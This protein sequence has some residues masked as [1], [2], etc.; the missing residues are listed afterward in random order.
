MILLPFLAAVVTAAP[1]A[2]VSAQNL[3]DAKCIA[4]IAVTMGN[5]TDETEKSGLTGGL[6]YYI[7]RIDARTPGFD[8]TGEVIRLFNDKNFTEN[9]IKVDAQR[10]GAE[11]TAKG[12][13]V[14]AFGEA[15]RQAG[16]TS[17]D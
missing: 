5:A 13:E 8:Y 16:Q 4:I 11:M 2:P 7:G 9:E 14:Q 10:C 17:G 6:I 1:A 15:L 3:S 12:K